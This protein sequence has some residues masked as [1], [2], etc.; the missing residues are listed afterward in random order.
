MLEPCGSTTS[1]SRVKNLGV[2]RLELS[3]WWHFYVGN[4]PAQRVQ[5]KA[6][7][8]DAVCGPIV[9]FRKQTKLR[10]ILKIWCVFSIETWKLEFIKWLI[11]GLQISYIHYFILSFLLSL[12]SQASAHTHPFTAAQLS[13]LLLFWKETF[14]PS[15]QHLPSLSLTLKLFM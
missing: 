15:C 7:S 14:L 13:C 8:A 5:S 4:L 12:L 11:W 2:P 10:S 3:P 6:D 1:Q 9:H